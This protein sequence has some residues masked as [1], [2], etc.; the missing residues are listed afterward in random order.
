L[1]AGRDSDIYV[2]A[3]YGDV[4]WA[5]VCLDKAVYNDLERGDNDIYNIPITYRS[6]TIKGIPLNELRIEID[7]TGE[8]EANWEEVWITPC[9]GSMRL[10]DPI[11]L[12]GKTFEDSK[13]DT[14]F[15]SKLKN[16]AYRSNQ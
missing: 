12:G 8:D 7:R 2:V 13:W 3:Y 6:S 15:Q 10:T 1:Y 9:Y 5:K 16:A 11:S 4:K 14:N